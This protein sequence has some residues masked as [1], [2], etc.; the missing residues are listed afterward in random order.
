MSSPCNSYSPTKREIQE[1]APTILKALGAQACKNTSDILQTSMTATTAADFLIFSAD[2]T[3]TTEYDVSK[4]SSIGCEQI[5]VATKQYIASAKKI[6]CILNENVTTSSKTLNTGNSIIFRSQNGDINFDGPLKINQSIEIVMIDL[7]QLS[8]Q[9]KM[10]IADEVKQ[11]A[12]QSVEAIQESTTGMGAT[13]QGSKTVSDQKTEITSEN[14]NH[15]VE[16]VIN[17]VSITLNSQNDILIETVNGNI[18]IKEA[19]IDQNILINLT[20]TL[21]IDNSLNTVFKSLANAVSTQESK[22]TQIANNLGADTLGGQAGEAAAS[23]LKARALAKGGMTTI[24]VGLIIFSIAVFLFFKIK[25][26]GGPQVPQSGPSPFITAMLPPPYRVAAMAAQSLQAMQPAQP[27][28]GFRGVQNG[29]RQHNIRNDNGIDSSTAISIFGF[30]LGLLFCIAGITGVIYYF[31][32]DDRYM[33]GLKKADQ[34]LDKCI[35]RV[36]KAC[37]FPQCTEAICPT[38][39]DKRKVKTC[40][41]EETKKGCPKAKVDDYVSPIMMQIVSEVSIG[42]GILIII[43]S[44]WW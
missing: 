18:N 31:T 13:P 37:P 11:T 42:I 5:A 43:Q 16:K 32:Y 26:S 15:I 10:D 1:T 2:A 17:E 38:P 6:A 35:S 40:V 7:S 22:A 30:I 29:R 19:D 12:L 28:V 24:I 44:I 8:S 41:D 14:I 21:I 20:A 36:D 33:K 39:A 9:S 3:V 23:I 27:P 25:G 34:A 4:T